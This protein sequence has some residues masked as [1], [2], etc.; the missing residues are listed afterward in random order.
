MRDTYFAQSIADQLAVCKG[1]I[2]KWQLFNAMTGSTCARS[3]P[4]LNINGFDCHVSSIS[5]EDGSGSSFNLV[6]QHG[7]QSYRVYC[8]TTD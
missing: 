2:S 8:R 7:R 1:Q 3:Q 5:R 6:V 4:S